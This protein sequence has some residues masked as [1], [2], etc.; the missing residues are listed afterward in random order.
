MWFGRRWAGRKFKRFLNR[1]TAAAGS[2]P[3]GFHRFLCRASCLLSRLRGLA[4]LQIA[5]C[6]RD[7][8]FPLTRSLLGQLDATVNGSLCTARYAICRIF[9]WAVFFGAGAVLGLFLGFDQGILHALRGHSGL[10]YGLDRTLHSVPRLDL[11]HCRSP[12]RRA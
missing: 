12:H 6:L 3:C 2:L 7:R 10:V 11:R 8:S 4:L 5:L 9:L 1:E